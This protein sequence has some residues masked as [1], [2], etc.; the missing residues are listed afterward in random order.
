MAGVGQALF[1]LREIFRNPNLRRVQLAYAGSIVG[2]YSFSV[3]LAIYAY[4]HGGAGAVGVLVVL[5]TVPAAIVSPFAAVLGD[6]VRRE[7]VMLAS[8]LVRAAAVGV[9]R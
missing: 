1:A 2:Q 3:A 7:R 5:R 4:R 9:A 6:R 8:D